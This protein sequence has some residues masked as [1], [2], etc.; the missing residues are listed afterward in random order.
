M[1]KIFLSYTHIFP[2]IG[3]KSSLSLYFKFPVRGAG[4]GGSDDDSDRDG[5][6]YY[7]YYGDND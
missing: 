1:W 4:G 5:D 3:A 2:E 6:D 7:C